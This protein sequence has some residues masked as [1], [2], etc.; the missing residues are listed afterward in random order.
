[1]PF[2]AYAGTETN[3]TKPTFQQHKNA[4]FIKMVGGMVALK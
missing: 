4:V 2:L 1:M 3:M